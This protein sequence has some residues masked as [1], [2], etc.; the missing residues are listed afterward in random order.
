MEK[1]LCEK[2]LVELPHGACYLEYYLIRHPILSVPP[3]IHLSTYGVE[4]V[5]RSCDDGEILET[6]MIAD[7]CC[8]VMQMNDMISILAK[9]T[10]TPICL[11][12]VI[13]DFLAE[14][15]GKC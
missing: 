7:V 5:K 15:N 13:E 4:V 8:S 3:R 6:K 14:E 9:N 12:D 1:K 10:V 11:H 2:V